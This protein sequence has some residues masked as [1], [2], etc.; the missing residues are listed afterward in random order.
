MY[1]GLAPP[2]QWCAQEGE[3]RAKARGT[4]LTKSCASIPP[5]IG[6]CVQKDCIHKQNWFLDNYQTRWPLA[7]PGQRP[8]TRRHAARRTGTVEARRRSVAGRVYNLYGDTANPVHFAGEQSLPFLWTSQSVR[9]CFTFHSIFSLLLI[10]V[11]FRETKDATL[12]LGAG[13]VFRFRAR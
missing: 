11:N 6:S 13:Q 7:P 8:T 12:K 5:P 4:R 2:T 9:G 10:P 1:G 3:M